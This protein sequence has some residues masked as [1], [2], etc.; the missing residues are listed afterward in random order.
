[1][2]LVSARGR[3]ACC[4]PWPVC[5]KRG[6]GRGPAC[7]LHA[8]TAYQQGTPSRRDDKSAGRTR[9]LQRAA[10]QCRVKIPLAVTCPLQPTSNSNWAA[11]GPPDGW[12]LTA[13]GSRQQE[14]GAAFPRACLS[15][16]SSVRSRCCGVRSSGVLFLGV[17]CYAFV[18]CLVVKF[19]LDFAT[20]ALLFLFV[21]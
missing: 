10:V 20:V 17:S 15:G 1:M 13:A 19:F 14:G 8:C 7:W 3:A 11:A 16:C 12:R 9:C 2:E 18:T 6:P 4:V 21:L 5:L